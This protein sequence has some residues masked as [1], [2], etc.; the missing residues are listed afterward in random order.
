[1]TNNTLDLQALKEATTTID[2]LTPAA[3]LALSLRTLQ[4]LA[5]DPRVSAEQIRDY[6][7]NVD[8]D[9]TDEAWDIFDD[10]P[11]DQFMEIQ[12]ALKTLTSIG[13]S[14]DA[15]LDLIQAAV[16]ALPDEEPEVT[17]GTAPTIES[18]LQEVPKTDCGAT[19]GCLPTLTPEGERL[20]EFVSDHLDRT[21][22]A[23]YHLANTGTLGDF[24]LEDTTTAILNEVEDS[25]MEWHDKEVE[26]ILDEER[27][28]QQNEREILTMI[29]SVFNFNEAADEGSQIGRP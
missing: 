6:I 15:A 19:C 9:L 7:V 13:L 29:N 20:R 28:E 1:M 22:N 16:N 24:S 26:T 8:D 17:G 4:E 27:E 14:V 12:D 23:G 18:L 21:F 3:E 11:L 10:A 2:N 25:F 5:L